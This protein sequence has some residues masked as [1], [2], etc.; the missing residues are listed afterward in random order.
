MKKRIKEFYKNN[1]GEIVM[2]G[3][4]ILI[5][6]C[7]IPVMVYNVSRKTSLAKQAA[8]EDS[9]S[10]SCVKISGKG[11]TP[12]EEPYR[13]MTAEDEYQ[14]EADSIYG[15]RL[16]LPEPV[17][18]DME[19][20]TANYIVNIDYDFEVAAGEYGSVR[21]VMQ[22]AT[23][24]NRY[25][26]AQGKFKAADDLCLKHFVPITLN[27]AS[28]MLDHHFNGVPEAISFDLKTS[29]LPDAGPK[30]TN[31]DEEMP[32]AKFSCHLRGREEQGWEEEF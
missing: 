24:S 2:A 32:Y 27:G 6:C 3:A 14:F 12:R 8:L 25:Y 19:N 16:V 22:H 11:P 9:Y 5:V 20:D 13:Q 10:L 7:L 26:V 17:F 31:F 29:A 23:D 28:A 18:A 1:G 4:F 21:I 15:I 30:V